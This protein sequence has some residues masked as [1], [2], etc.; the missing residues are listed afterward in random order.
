MWRLSV[1]VCRIVIYIRHTTSLERHAMFCTILIVLA[2]VAVCFSPALILLPDL[3]NKD[4][5]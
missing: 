1:D 4:N 2:I 3:F 5:R